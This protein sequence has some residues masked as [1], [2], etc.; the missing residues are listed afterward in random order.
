MQEYIKENI[1]ESVDCK[2]R[3]LESDSLICKIEEVARLGIDIY[4]NGSKILACGNGGSAS[5]AQ[6]L[7]GELV[8]R[9]MLER[10]GIP[11]IALTANSTVM[12]ALANDYDYESVFAK[13]VKAYGNKGD[14]LIGISTSGNSQ[15]VIKAFEKAHEMGIITVGFT[16]EKGG[17]M[18]NVSDYLINVPSDST[19]RIQEMH[20]LVIHIIC[21]LIEGGLFE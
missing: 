16:G 19:P 21:G 13:Q 11:A 3:L 14:V 17:N 18:K 7:V 1:R 4:K 10:N 9:Y 6:H 2:A 8:G 15:N 20:I 5:D 12:T